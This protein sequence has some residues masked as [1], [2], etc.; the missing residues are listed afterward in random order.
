VSSLVVAQG[1]F[2]FAFALVGVD[3][4]RENTRMSGCLDYAELC[5]E[6]KLA[7]CLL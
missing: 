4:V 6:I 3:F 5:G 1:C 7:F 2:A